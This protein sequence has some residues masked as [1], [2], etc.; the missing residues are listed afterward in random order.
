MAAHLVGS[1][2]AKMAGL[3]VAWMA[4][5]MDVRLVGKLAAQ[6]AVQMGRR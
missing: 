3:S 5:P 6:K 4:A 2:A 1:K